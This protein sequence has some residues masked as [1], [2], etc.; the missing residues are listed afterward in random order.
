MDVGRS[1][2]RYIC[3][4]CGSEGW[5]TSFSGPL[6][7][8]SSRTCPNEAEDWHSQ[9]LK[10]QQRIGAKYSACA[11]LPQSI[12]D[13]NEAEVAILKR[14]LADLR[15]VNIGP[16]VSVGRIAQEVEVN[17]GIYH[18]GGKSIRHH[19]I[20]HPR[21]EAVPNEWR[22][23]KGYGLSKTLVS[24]AHRAR[25]D[26][27]SGVV[28]HLV[29]SLSYCDSAHAVGNPHLLD[30]ETVRPAT[31][32]ELLLFNQ[33][34]PDVQGKYPIVA[35]GDGPEEPVSYLY[36]WP[37]HAKH[38]WKYGWPQQVKCSFVPDDWTNGLN[39]EPWETVWDCSCVFLWVNRE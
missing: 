24:P 7:G 33:Q 27:D 32:E 26:R 22:H 2:R 30:I 14:Q 37:D 34:F 20:P 9:I 11:D 5:I 4:T 31:R 3:T 25:F 12:R 15:S 36:D 35:L 29:G 28:F 39:E 10:L 17:L 18:I 23:G 8:S 16:N 38:Y 13:E 1:S 19:E 6:G 21:P